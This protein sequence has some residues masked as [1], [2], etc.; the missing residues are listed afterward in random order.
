MKSQK[1][2]IKNR[3]HSF[4]H[5]FNGL[6]ILLKEEHNSRIHILA[7]IGVVLAGFYFSISTYEWLAVIGVSGLVISLEIINSAIENMADFV[8]AEKHAAI[9]RIKD[10]SA[11]SVLVG[12]LT[13]LIV[14]ILIFVP[15]LFG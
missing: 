15:K 9:K 13:A 3:I 4:K 5:A 12:A 2:S 7:I 11:A 8:C 10:L 1:F 6:S 14:G